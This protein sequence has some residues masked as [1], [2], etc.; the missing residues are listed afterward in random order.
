MTADLVTQLL[1]HIKLVEAIARA[2]TPG[3]WRSYASKSTG[4]VGVHAAG[5]G[6]DVALMPRC[7]AHGS[8]HD[9]DASHIALNDPAWVLRRCAAD[10]ETLGEYTTTVRL[11]DEAADRLRAQ[12][13]HKDHGDLDTWC[14]ADTEVSILQPVIERMARTYG[15]ST[16][17]V[18]DA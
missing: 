7:D 3:P 4:D 12:G 11:R 10:R 1:A 2:A 8:R 5:D 16:E 13:E 6:H 9:S 15:L 17:V 14:R 18:D